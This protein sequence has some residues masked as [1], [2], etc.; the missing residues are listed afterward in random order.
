MSA[1][2]RG[3]G[4]VQPNTP[5]SISYT[6]SIT[7]AD[8]E[9]RRTRLECVSLPPALMTAWR[10]ALDA[11]SAVEGWEPMRA[12]ADDARAHRGPYRPPLSAERPAAVRARRSGPQRTSFFVGR[13]A[14]P[15]P[16]AEPEA[17]AG[18][19]AEGGN[20]TST[21]SSSNSI[22]NNTTSGGGIAIVAHHKVSGASVFVYPDYDGL[23]SSGVVPRVVEG[24][25]GGEEEEERRAHAKHYIAVPDMTDDER[26]AYEALTAEWRRQ[27][28]ARRRLERSLQLDATATP[29]GGGGPG[30]RKRAREED[31]EAVALEL[32]GLGGEEFDAE[33][34]LQLADDLLH[35]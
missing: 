11:H 18:G 8:L 27:T 2:S 9:R 7:R 15:V 1:K 24:G 12:D 33:A 5:A 14:V 13:H 16:P 28:D 32:D 19:T 6:S 3:A 21:G 26:V 31:G 23:L 34:V 35:F 29:V 25:G 10:A 30:E 4:F 20:T 22:N 17:G